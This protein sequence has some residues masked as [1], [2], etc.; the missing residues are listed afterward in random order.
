MRAPTTGWFSVVLVPQT[1]IVAA[2]SMSSNELVA[3]PVPNIRFSATALGAWQTRAQ[4]ST[5][6]VPS[7][8]R[9]SFWTR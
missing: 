7:T 1:R 9:A 4:Q 8:A 3:A 2:R 5:L 6:L